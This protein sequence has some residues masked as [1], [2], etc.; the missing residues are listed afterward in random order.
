M[1]AASRSEAI[2]AIKSASGLSDFDREILLSLNPNE[3]DCSNTDLA[4]RW[5]LIF[6]EI[7]SIDGAHIADL[8]MDDMDKTKEIA[9][10]ALKDA[11]HG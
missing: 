8:L 4:T 6:G 7:I 10:K 9:L 5:F 11:R 3:F 1:R 2:D